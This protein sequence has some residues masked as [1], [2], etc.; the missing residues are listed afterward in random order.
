MWDWKRL[1][2]LVSKA[3]EYFL[4]TTEGQ[5]RLFGGAFVVL[6]VVGGSMFALSAEL[7]DDLLHLGA[8]L[9]VFSVLIVLCKNRP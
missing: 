7:S 3:L 6:A 2:E 9:I 8:A 4:N 5:V 1:I